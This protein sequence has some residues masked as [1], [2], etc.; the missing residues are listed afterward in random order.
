MKRA[1][2]NVFLAIAA[3]FGL[4]LLLNDPHHRSTTRNPIWEPVN[5][6]GSD[7][8]WT[9]PAG[10]RPGQQTE[11]GEQSN[12][13][14]PVIPTLATTPVPVYVPPRVAARSIAAESPRADS[15]L[16]PPALL[17]HESPVKA[18]VYRI[19]PNTPN[20]VKFAAGWSEL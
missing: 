13:R 3:A 4:A 15:R 14:L 17:K 7:T 11:I 20:P 9:E 18:A 2:V 19:G 8:Q 12:L 6:R 16:L 1:D 5:L 10:F